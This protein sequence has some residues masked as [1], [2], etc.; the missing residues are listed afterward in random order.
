M[1]CIFSKIY[2]IFFLLVM[3]IPILLLPPDIRMNVL[4]VISGWSILKYSLLLG[5][6]LDKHYS[7][8]S[9]RRRK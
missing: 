9:R 6:R 3:A 7:K 4:Y 8:R 2:A 5:S 1:S